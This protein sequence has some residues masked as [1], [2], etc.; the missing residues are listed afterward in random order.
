MRRSRLLLSSAWP[1]SQTSHAD[2]CPRCPTYA[3]GELTL[4]QISNDQQQPSLNAADNDNDNEQQQ[5]QTMQ[6]QSARTTTQ[7]IEVEGC[8]CCVD[9]RGRIRRPAVC[10]SDTHTTGTISELLVSAVFSN[11]NVLNVVCHSGEQFSHQWEAHAEACAHSSALCSLLHAALS[12]G[13]SGVQMVR[14]EVLDSQPHPHRAHD[15]HH[16]T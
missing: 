4:L 12:F 15:S 1:P 11:N 6:P 5:P 3:R 2:G 13:L 14:E 10:I 7:R 8:T 9:S 16:C